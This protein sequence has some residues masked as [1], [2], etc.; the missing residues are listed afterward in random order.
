[1]TPVTSFTACRALGPPKTLPL[2]QVSK[3]NSALPGRL[4]R[5]FLNSSMGT[6]VHCARLGTALACA[7]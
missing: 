7:Q 5:V 1:L 2:W 3:K 6:P 4:A